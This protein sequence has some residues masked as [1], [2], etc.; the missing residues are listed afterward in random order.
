MYNHRSPEYNSGLNNLN[1]KLLT[2]TKPWREAERIIYKPRNYHI[3][4][5]LPTLSYTVLSLNTLTHALLE[6]DS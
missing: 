5:R 3:T 4:L 1:P 2:E 6:A